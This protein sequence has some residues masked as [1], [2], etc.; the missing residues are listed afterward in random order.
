MALF[1]TF[2]TAVY[3]VTELTA[4]LK[5]LVSGRFRNVR[6]E[7]EVSNAKLYPSGHLYFTLKD[8]AAM[9]K[10]VA[11]NYRGKFSGQAPAKRGQ[12]IVKDGD[13]V[14]CE[15]KVDVYERRIPAHRERHDGKD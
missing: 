5:Q 8:E 2:E 4:I 3:T 12:A 14:V 7:G 1:P 6:V 10:A 13:T 9:M 11:F 15:G